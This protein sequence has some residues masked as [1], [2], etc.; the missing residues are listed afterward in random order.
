MFPNR[1]KARARLARRIPG[2]LELARAR[3]LRQD[4][5]RVVEQREQLRCVARDAEREVRIAV[6]L[7]SDVLVHSGNAERQNMFVPVLVDLL[8][9]P[10]PD[11]RAIAANGLGQLKALPSLS[12]P[13]LIPVVDDPQRLPRYHAALALGSFGA[14][15]SNAVPALLAYAHKTGS[16]TER[17]LIIQAIRKIDPGLADAPRPVRNR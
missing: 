9:D 15:A 10:E 5:L 14:A 3:G 11:V 7:C 17:Q 16:A 1:R 4:E 2:M 13:A 12:V 8:K 6:A